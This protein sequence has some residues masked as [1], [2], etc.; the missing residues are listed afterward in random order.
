VASPDTLNQVLPEAKTIGTSEAWAT[1]A[2]FLVVGSCV[3]V[4]APMVPIA[5][6]RLSLGE[7][8]LGAILLALGLGSIV[9]MPLSGGLV[10][11]FGGRR[12]VLAAALMALASL[13]FM[14]TAGSPNLLAAALLVFGAGIGVMDVAMNIQAVAVETAMR[15]PMMSGFHAMYSVG[16]IV[17]A[18][19]ATW[20][21]TGGATPLGIGLGA[22][23]ISIF[24]LATA[25]PGLIRQVSAERTPAIALPKGRVLTLGLLCFVLFLAEGCVLDWSG[26]LLDSVYEVS[27]D[28]AG[29]GYAVFA[30]TMTLGRLL[31]DRI[32][33]TV[34]AARVMVL[35]CASAGLGYFLAAF[36]GHWMISVAGF[37]LV[38]IGASNVVPVLFTEAGR[39]RTMPST[40]AIAAVTTLGYAG[41]LAGP[42]AIGFLAS[43]VGL[44]IA[45]G[46]VG[47]A[48][49]ISGGIGI[50]LA[51]GR[52]PQEA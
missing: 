18:G 15:K 20:A 41:I 47:V 46:A 11:R 8:Q 12:V 49:L 4:W 27:L 38:G 36:A 39:D 51:I 29:I 3:G 40:L 34:G 32:V 13:P 25:F 31:G 14:A 48:L 43:A 9:A 37:A 7:A 28:R 23:A 24:L 19:G 33:A 52:P 1:R 44:P 5:K 22:V 30:A 6:Q 50:S 45:L 42:A 17:G 10:A 26:V 16:G 35:G 2:T 21:L